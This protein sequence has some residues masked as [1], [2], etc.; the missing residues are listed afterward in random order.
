MSRE[1]KYYLQALKDLLPQLDFDKALY[2]EGTTI[3][4]VVFH[5]CQSA[6]YWTRVAILR[7]SFER[8][9]NLEFKEIPS[10]EQIN[11]SLDMAIEACDL[12]EKA[13]PDLN[14]N[15]EKPVMLMPVNFEAKTNLDALIHVIAHTAEHYGE[16]FQTTR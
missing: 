9:R 2:K 11:S 14:Q 7:L 1:L 15:L 3:G 12:L 5:C 10:L 13:N 4:H 16:L 8:N 6:N